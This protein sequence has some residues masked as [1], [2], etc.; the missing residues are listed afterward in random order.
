VLL[1]EDTHEIDDNRLDE[2]GYLMY[3]EGD[4]RMSARECLKLC[5]RL[6][7]DRIFLTE[8]RDDAHGITWPART[9]GTLG[10]FSRRTLTARPAPQRVLPRW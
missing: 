6:S 9:R 5:M 3:G 7:P 2:V 1:M 8:L 10:A 4:G